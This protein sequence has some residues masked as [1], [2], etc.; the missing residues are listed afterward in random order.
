MSQRDDDYLWFYVQSSSDASRLVA[1]HAANKKGPFIDESNEPLCWKEWKRNC[2]ADKKLSEEAKS[3]NKTTKKK[4]P[5]QLS[6]ESHSDIIYREKLVDNIS[7]FWLRKRSLFPFY[8]HKNTRYNINGERNH[9]AIVNHTAGEMHLTQ[10]AMLVRCLIDFYGDRGYFDIHPQTYIFCLRSKLRGNNSKLYNAENVMNQLIPNIEMVQQGKIPKLWIVKPSTGSCGRGISILDLYPDNF[11]DL[12]TED[13][14]VEIHNR[15]KEITATH[16]EEKS[17][18]LIYQSYIDKPL[19]YKGYKFD[20]RVYLMIASVK[21]PFIAL[22]SKQGYLR[23]C[24]DPYNT[25]FKNRNA[26]ITNFHVQRDHPLY[27][28]E[29]DSIEGRTTRV[30][31]KDFISYLHE[32]DF[33]KQFSDDEKASVVCSESDDEDPNR[34]LIIALLNKRVYHCISQAVKSSVSK[35]SGHPNAAEGQFAL[36]GVDLLVDEFGNIWLIEFTKSPAFRMAPNYLKDL[37][38]QVLCEC[39]DIATDIEYVRQKTPIGQ[40]IIPEQVPAIKNAKSWALLD[41]ST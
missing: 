33:I 28:K 9:T 36:L 18:E 20:F 41:V 13:L 22:Y 12:S 16:D 38:T 2:K 23:V 27:N 24:S 37:H 11:K 29:T 34:Q 31:Y 21:S 7:V 26:H 40:D 5:D 3:S 35:I 10:K 15:V 39:F 6:S 17:P 14:Q 19:L 32:V 8:Y 30:E 4:K 1:Y 25:D